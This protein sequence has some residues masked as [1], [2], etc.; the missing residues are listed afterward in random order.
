[1][2]TSREADVVDY[3]NLLVEHDEGFVTLTINRPRVLNALSRATVSELHAAI[4][5]IAG[6]DSI[7]ALVITGSGRKA[8]VSGAD[9]GELEALE[10]AQQGFEHSKYSH[11]LLFKLQEL[12]KAVIMAVNGYALGGGCELALGGDIIIASENAQFGQPEVNLG[13]IPGFG[14]TQRLPRLVGRTRALELILTGRRISAEEAFAMGLVN[15]V[16]SQDELMSTAREIAATI[17]QKAPLA[18]ALAKRAVYEGLEM[19]PRAGNEAEMTYFGLAVGTSDR[20]EGTAA[21]LQKRSP[22]WQGK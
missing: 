18:I 16:V 10:T 13:I 5:S 11:E 1:M 4:D 3:E 22:N 6:D 2:T 12:P 9:I 19:G 7:R 15:R 14:G 17:A 8:F 21:F 20:V